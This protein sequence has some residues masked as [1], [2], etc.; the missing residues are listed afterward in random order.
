MYCE[1]FQQMS[2][3]RVECKQNVFLKKEWK[4]IQVKVLIGWFQSVAAG[5]QI[6]KIPRCWFV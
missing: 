3:I 2:S 6:M 5:L 4:N 1:Y